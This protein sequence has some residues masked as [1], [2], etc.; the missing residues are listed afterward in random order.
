MPGM[1]GHTFIQLVRQEMPDMRGVLMSGYTEEVFR[2][3]ISRDR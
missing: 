3:E 2:E 1:D